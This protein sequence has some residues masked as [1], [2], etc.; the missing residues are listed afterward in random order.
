MPLKLIQELSGRYIPQSNRCVL[1]GGCDL[2]AI[3][4]K[5]Q[6]VDRARVAAQIPLDASRGQVA[7]R[8]K[9]AVVARCQKLAVGRKGDSSDAQRLLESSQLFAGSG[10]PDLDCAGPR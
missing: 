6:P 1:A 2:L 5:N 3:G 9:T 8:R 4:Q 10:V 7:E